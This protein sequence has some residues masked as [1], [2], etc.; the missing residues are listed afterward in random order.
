MKHDDNPDK[1]NQS[2]Q[3]PPT[4]HGQRRHLR[5]GGSHLAQSEFTYAQVE[6]LAFWVWLLVAGLKFGFGSGI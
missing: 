6:G 1:L 5:A 2:L 4:C 3:E